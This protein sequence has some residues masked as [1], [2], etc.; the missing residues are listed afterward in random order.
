MIGVANCLAAGLGGFGSFHAV[1]LTQLAHR[2]FGTPTRVVGVTAS[3]VLLALLLGG[4]SLFALLPVVLIAGVLGYIGI[5]LLYRWTWVERRRMPAQDFAIVLLI[6]AVAATLG[7]IPAVVTGALAAC[8]RFVLVY[9]RLQVIRSRQTGATRLSSVERSEPAVR[10]LMARGPET[11]IFELQGYL[12]FGTASRLGAAIGRE[13]EEG[14]ADARQVVVDFRRVLG[15]DMSAAYQLV[16]LARAAE[17][18]GLTLSLT[19]LDA[20]TRARLLDLGVH[21]EAL[22]LATLDEAL[23]ESEARTLA[24]GDAEPWERTRLGV[25]LQAIEASGMGEVLARETVPAGAT[26]LRQGDASD[27]LLLLERGRSSPASQVRTPGRCGWQPSFLAPWWA[28]SATMPA[29]PAQR[30]CAP[31]SRASSAGSPPRRWRASPAKSPGSRGSSTAGWPASSRA[32][33]RALPPS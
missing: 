16:R 28:R 22:A 13:I 18:R 15:L 8:A 19:G 10:T 1:G 14:D 20:A 7:F 26:L 12:F 23:L 33:W 2:L 24:A 6:L 29:P 3:I 31:R 27:G 4:A 5:D 11:L 32:G 25:L 21:S 30:P 9:S 17:R